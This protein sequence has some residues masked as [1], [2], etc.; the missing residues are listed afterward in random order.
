MRDIAMGC[1]LVAILG[2][3]PRMFGVSLMILALIPI[4]DAIII[5][6]NALQP[7]VIALVLHISSAIVFLV[8]GLWFRLG[9]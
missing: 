1:W 8:L 6:M 2:A 9:R 7:S 5:S 3:G 4:G